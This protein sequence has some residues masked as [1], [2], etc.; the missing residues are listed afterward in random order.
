MSTTAPAAHPLQHL[1]GR[2]VPGGEFRI[3]SYESWLAHDALYS[4]PGPVPHPVMAFIAAQRGM[5]CTVAELFRMLDSDIDDG[6]LLASTT[7]DVERDLATDETYRVTGAVT[8]LVR[9]HGAALGD[10]DLVTCE[11]TLADED[12]KGVATVTNIYAIGRNR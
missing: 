12:G 5:G 9:K 2:S 10:F 1:V 11:F 3:A 7:I 4:E 6:P 8:G